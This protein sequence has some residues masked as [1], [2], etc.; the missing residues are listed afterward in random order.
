MKL[1]S[2]RTAA[3]NAK[4]LLP[5]L[6]EKYFKSGR[7]AAEGKRSAKELHG[8]RFRTKQ[9]RYSLELFRPVYGP[10]LDRRLSSLRGLQSVLGKLSDYHSVRTM[11]AGD[12]AMEAK[13]ERAMKKTLKEF[14]K[15]WA[16]FDS[17]GQLK[18]W[19]TYLSR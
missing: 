10:S 3:E 17:E 4:V 2:S 18:R 5:K 9:F 19:K 6:A 8:F 13:I 7:T 14:R 11:L 12:K 1:K 16:S 15:Q